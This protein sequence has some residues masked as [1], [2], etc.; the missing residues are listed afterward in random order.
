MVMDR[1]IL[2]YC[3]RQQAAFRMAGGMSEWAGGDS[4]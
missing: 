4:Y 2:A 1:V 3:L